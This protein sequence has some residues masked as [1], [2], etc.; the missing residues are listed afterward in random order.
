MF[1]AVRGGFLV[2]LAVLLPPLAEQ[3][4]LLVEEKVPLHGLETG[5]IFNLGMTF[6]VLCPDA[7]RALHQQLTQLAQVAL[8]KE[9]G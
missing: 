4:S 1:E 9:G 6:L 3:Q 8:E 2:A 5:Q 7:E